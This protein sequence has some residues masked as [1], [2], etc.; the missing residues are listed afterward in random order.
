M[1][2]I[3][4]VANCQS[5][6]EQSVKPG[7][8]ASCIKLVGLQ[9]ADSPNAALFAAGGFTAN[10]DLINVSADTAAFFKGGQ[11]YQITIAPVS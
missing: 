3:T 7:A 1:N 2:P 5:K 9:G 10:L 4:I 6:S 8:V 11:K